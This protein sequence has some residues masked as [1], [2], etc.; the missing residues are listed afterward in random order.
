MRNPKDEFTNRA[1][2]NEAGQRTTPH[3][4]V[5]SISTLASIRKCGWAARVLAP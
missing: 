1:D 5:G 3:R 4:R 2:L